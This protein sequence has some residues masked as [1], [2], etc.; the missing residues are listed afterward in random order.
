M[1][2]GSSKRGDSQTVSTHREPEHRSAQVCLSAPTESLTPKPGPRFWRWGQSWATREVGEAE[3]D[4]PL[5]VCPTPVSQ[6]SAG[7]AL[8]DFRYRRELF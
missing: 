4:A 6:S 7:L 2:V 3:G 8:P 5:P 1:S